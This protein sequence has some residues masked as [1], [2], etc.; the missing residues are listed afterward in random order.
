MLAISGSSALYAMYQEHHSGEG[1]TK[2]LENH[3]TRLQQWQPYTPKPSREKKTSLHI[4]SL[5]APNISW[6]TPIQNQVGIELRQKFP[7][8][9]YTRS[10]FHHSGQLSMQV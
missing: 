5:L 3:L 6:A 10:L 1:I 8:R 7:I 4:R 9:L 2:H